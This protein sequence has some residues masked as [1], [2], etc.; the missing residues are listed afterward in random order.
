MLQRAIKS[1]KGIGVQRPG[2]AILSRVAKESFT[3]VPNDQEPERDK[4][5]K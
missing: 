1:G 4:E 3:K 2:T 5:A